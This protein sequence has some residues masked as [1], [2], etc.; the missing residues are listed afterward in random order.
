MINGLGMVSM[1]RFNE[2]KELLVG[3]SIRHVEGCSLFLDNGEVLHMIDWT[4]DKPNDFSDWFNVKRNK[5]I[6]DIKLK[7]VAYRK[8][9]NLD[10]M[11]YGRIV[12]EHYGEPIAQVYASMLHL[13]N[14]SKSKCF[15]LLDKRIYDIFDDFE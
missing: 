13:Q 9:A 14:M 8:F 11:Y 15:L 3:C 2:L 4:P 6:T 10:T 12:L 1:E 5:E 7:N